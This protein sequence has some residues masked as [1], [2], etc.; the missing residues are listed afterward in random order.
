MNLQAMIL[1]FQQVLP[2]LCTD[3]VWVPIP[4]PSP[5]ELEASV[6]VVWWSRGWGRAENLCISGSQPGIILPLRHLAMPGGIFNSHDIGG[7]AGIC[8]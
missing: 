1:E 7:A 5:G 6:G 8:G 3:V 2:P 4:V